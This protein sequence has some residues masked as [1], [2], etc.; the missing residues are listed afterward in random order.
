MSPPSTRWLPPDEQKPVASD[1]ALVSL[2]GH[3]Q[4]PDY[5]RDGPFSE[6]QG[7]DCF[8]NDIAGRIYGLRSS[9]PAGGIPMKISKTEASCKWKPGQSF[10]VNPVKALS[11]SLPH[12]YPSVVAAGNGCRQGVQGLE[13]LPLEQ[14]GGYG[15]R[16]TQE[17]RDRN[18]AS[19][20]R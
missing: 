15:S 3:S 14:A 6:R 19:G 4:Q 8:D 7:F 16:P 9:W 1:V 2:G 13:R 17:E 18:L 10:T 12:T 5:Q 20:E 11:H